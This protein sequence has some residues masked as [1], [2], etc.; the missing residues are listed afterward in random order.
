ML[1]ELNSVNEMQA[2]SRDLFECGTISMAICHAVTL[3]Y[4][5]TGMCISF[6][7]FHIMLHHNCVVTLNH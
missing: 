7:I 1:A 2:R 6:L 5:C 4:T 3:K